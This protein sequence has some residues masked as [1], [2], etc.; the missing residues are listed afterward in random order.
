MSVGEVIDDSPYG[1]YRILTYNVGQGFLLDNTPLRATLTNHLTRMGYKYMRDLYLPTCISVVDDLT[2]VPLRICSDNPATRDLLIVDVLMAS[3][4]MP[5]IFPAQQIANYVPPFGNGFFID[6]GVGIDMIPTAE[7]YQRNLDAVY[8]L[9]R[10]WELNNK[11]ALPPQLQNIKI[12]ANT[13]ST[14]EDLLQAAFFSGL[15]SAATARTASYAY[16]P[17]LPVDFGVLDFDSGKAMYDMTYN[18]TLSNGP[19]LLN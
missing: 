13:I 4:A 19:T 17:V 2:G 16:V 15:S 10:Q 12:L 6:G 18:W 9:T 3:A 11:T 5:V 1:I 14:F 7:A 8:I